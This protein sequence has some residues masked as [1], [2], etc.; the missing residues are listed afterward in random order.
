MENKDSQMIRNYMNLMES[1]ENKLLSDKVIIENEE[2]QTI[3]EI[4]RTWIKTYGGDAKAL[5]SAEPALYGAFIDVL[6]VAK[7]DKNQIKGLTKLS[8]NKFVNITNIDDLLYALRTD[9]GITNE[10]LALFN[11]GLLKSA[12][13]P[14]QIIDDI[15]KEVVTSDTFIKNYGKMTPKEMESS[16]KSKGYSDNAVKSL[17]ENAKKDKKFMSSRKKGIEKRKLKKTQSGK[18]K[19]LKTKTNGGAV[20]PAQKTT[21]TKRA[22][23]LLDGVKNKKWNWKKVLAWGASIGVGSLALW[24]ALHDRSEIVPDDLPENEPMPDGEWASCIQNLINNK[25][26]VLTTTESGQVYV[27]VTKTSNKE[28]DKMG[29]L[30]FYNNGRV[31]SY[32]NTKRGYWTCKDGEAV[33]KEMSLNEQSSSLTQ[34]V[35]TMVDLLDFPV[36]GSDLTNAKNLLQK[37]TT[38]GQ[39]K[40]FLNLYQKTGL[41]GGSLKKSLNYIPTFNASSVQLKDSLNSLINKINSGS[42]TSSTGSVTST[43]STGGGIGNI[44]ITWDGENTTPTTEPTTTEP[45]TPKVSS[46]RGTKKS[47]FTDSNKFPYVF[48]QRSPIIKEIQICFGFPKKW[49]TGNFGPIT[50]KKLRDL[51]GVS[52]INEYTY[53]LIK[54]KC[55]LK[56]T[57]GTTANTGTSSNTGT[58]TTSTTQ[59]T[60]TSTT[61]PTPTTT[62]TTQPIK[63]PL[64]RENCEKLFKEILKRDD[65]NGGRTATDEEIAKCQKCLQQYNFGI[66]QGA[67]KIKRAYAL[68]SSGGNKGIRK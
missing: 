39:G 61:Q 41:G 19:N 8:P 47:K 58:T 28:W 55:K 54:E 7:T 44:N 12:K 9:R 24:W 16:L 57:T 3:N 2:V 6:S 48:G 30:R 62:S 23:E 56:P 42:S 36:T 60:T 37:Y 64:T 35:E 65:K 15:A 63:T 1:I 34:D 40:E 20:P 49:Q 32:D 14:A 33:I 53:N 67:A 68:T 18:D 29:G 22:Q 38:N 52:E 27:L 10:T 51:Y 11:Q 13:T 17:M 26:G 4:F 66:G 45:T 25:S 31:I 59:P 43:P 46:T 5:R 21:L 50:L